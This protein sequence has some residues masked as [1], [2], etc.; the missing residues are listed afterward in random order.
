[1]RAEVSTNDGDAL[2][3]DGAAELGLVL[4]VDEPFAPERDDRRDAHRLAELH[5]AG[6]SRPRAR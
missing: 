3:V 2:G 5:V 4:H 1:M 6:A